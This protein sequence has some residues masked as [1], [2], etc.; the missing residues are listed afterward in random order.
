MGVPE[1]V[2]K[3]MPTERIHERSRLL[4]HGE[5]C[6]LCLRSYQIGE[7]VRRLS[8]RHKFHIDCIGNELISIHLIFICFVIPSSFFQMDGFCIVIQHV[9]LMVNLYG[10]LKWK[11]NN[12]RQNGNIFLSS[13]V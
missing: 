10:I 13:I 6:R 4:Q 9:Q 5:Q 11:M 3:S 2:V 1:H 7:R 8:C 12:E